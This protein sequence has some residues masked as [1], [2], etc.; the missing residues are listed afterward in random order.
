MRLGTFC[1]LA[2]CTFFWALSFGLPDAD[3][4]SAP[5]ELF[6]ATFD[7]HPDRA[8]MAFGE[9]EQVITPHAIRRYPAKRRISLAPGK[10]GQALVQPHEFNARGNVSVARGTIAFWYRQEQP[11]GEMYYPILEVRTVE[12]YFWWRYLSLHGFHGR[13]HAEICD[14]DCRQV[15]F[16][17]PGLPQSEWIHIAVAWDALHGVR[18][19]KD[20]E[21]AASNWGEVQWPTEGIHLA[22][23]VLTCN[24]R[25]A[26]DE[27]RIFSEALTDAEVRQVF[28]NRPVQLEERPPLPDHWKTLRAV[29]LGWQNPGDLVA[30][31]P[32]Q[33]VVA[34]AVPVNTAKQL[35]RF[36]FRGVDGRSGNYYPSPYQGYR[37]L[38]GGGY[39]LEVPSGSRVN[40][41]T[42]E[43]RFRG[44]LYAGGALEPPPG[45]EPMIAIEPEGFVWR[46]EADPAELTEL[47]FFRRRLEGEQTGNE[48]E[49]GSVSSVSDFRSRMYHLQMFDVQRRA[50]PGGGAGDLAFGASLE[51]GLEHLPPWF[52]QTLVSLYT[53]PDRRAVLLGEADG[54]ASEIR[55]DALRH[56]HLF[57]P[58]AKEDFF[59]DAVTLS[60][61]DA[62]EGAK[63]RVVVQDPVTPKRLL[64]SLDA[65]LR[66][67]GRRTLTLNHVGTIIPPDARLWLT[68]TADRDMQMS[69]LQVTLHQGRREKVL[70]EYEP[71][72]MGMI[73]DIFMYMSE[74]R[75]WG[76]VDSR[77]KAQDLG[78]V[79]RILGD[80]Y[81]AL[82]QLRRHVRNNALAEGI[83]V[84]THPTAAHP[85][86]TARLRREHQGAPA[87]AAYAHLNLEY[88]QNW[89]HWW[90]DNRQAPNGE[91]G[92]NLGDDSDLVQEWP[93]LA[94]I[95]DPEGK[96]RR[97]VNMVG[98]ACWDTLIED[99]LNRRVTDALHAYEEGLN[100]TPHQA[101]LDY[102]NPYY[103]ERLMETA[104][105]VEDRLMG[106]TENGHL[107]FRS[108]YYG[109]HRVV[110]ELHYGVDRTTNTLM[111]HA[112]MFLMHYSRNP[113]ATRI[114]SE[115]VRAH[116]E[117]F[118]EAGKQWHAGVRF[119]DH[120]IV[121][122]GRSAL[123]GYGFLYLLS[124]V[125]DA[126]GD[127]LILQAMRDGGIAPQNGASYHAVRIMETLF[128]HGVFAQNRDYLLN[129]RNV[130]MG[131]LNTTSLS[132]PRFDWKYLEWRLTEDK[133]VLAAAARRLAERMSVTFAMHTEAEQSADRV[134]V[135]KK[136]IDRM[137]LGG[138]AAQRNDLHIR[139]HVSYEGLSRDFAALVLDAGPDR[140]KVL[141]YNFEPRPQT[142]A[143]RVWQLENGTYDV[144]FGRDLNEDDQIDEL[145]WRKSLPLRRR[146]PVE[147]VLPSRQLH[148]MEIAQTEKGD[149]LLAR[150]DLAVTHLDA[151]QVGG[152]W[153]FWVH[154]IGSSTAENVAVEVR[155]ARGALAASF[156]IEELEAPVD[157]MPR[158][159]PLSFAAQDFRPTFRVI[160][161]PEGL[162][163]E[164]CDENNVAVL[165]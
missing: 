118:Y 68:L 71:R 83:H 36:V 13:F 137:Y 81:E 9:S 117:D 155:D 75:P 89:A 19:Y 103:I 66:G 154:N 4:A 105:N 121:M 153:R 22:T 28:E 70:A 136:L 101:L 12:P 31:E 48:N 127:P 64:G 142:G 97:S 138:V 98:D 32:G 160:V 11:M 47:S 41:W 62:A 151:E 55:L 119:E 25:S 135:S 52:A 165:E 34:R 33:P 157:L 17:M 102:G 131:P 85:R 124:A 5:L 38:D 59:L 150:P 152:E 44:D 23:I 63:L 15:L 73:K 57:A 74:P 116:L 67:T 140:L 51:A 43:G 84:W 46:R 61:S 100:V 92:S 126:T 114:C 58:A 109:T 77:Q 26:Y 148:V 37:Y 60:W 3:A 147:I 145:A 14:R 93:S 132:D 87:W 49:K 69:E 86:G 164:I 133:D 24:R 156:T 123:H 91:F 161:D 94:L 76:H 53:P 7:E 27:L 39:H 134:Q 40:Y 1:A 107:H 6:R 122:Q 146:T 104:R 115:Y 158:K 99:G 108:W 149:D 96:I 129:A 106:R 50:Y 139:H 125:L 72:Q 112:A 2:A 21:L 110:D 79:H 162:I 10:V 80:L 82:H 163:A 45:Q 56:A 16:S 120:E 113:R 18:L 78:R 29:E 141:L 111:L 20:G 65:E 144:R 143:V 90:I 8:D 54:G 30:L 159:Q 128:P 130:D 88:F 95:S 42:I 35:K